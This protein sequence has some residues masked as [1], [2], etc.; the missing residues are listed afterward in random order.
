MSILAPGTI[1]LLAPA[2]DAATGMAAIRCGADAVYLGAPRFSAR[3]TAGNSISD[4]A[5]LCDLAHHYWARV[6]VALN[7]ILR[8]DELPHAVQ[9]A[10]AVAAAGA[11]GLIIQDVGLLASALPA[12]PLIASTQMHNDTPAKI[13]FLHEH[14]FARVILARELSLDELGRMRAAAPAIELECFVHG[15]VCVCYSGQCALSYALG[16]RSGNR[17]ACAQPCRRAY[18]LVDASGRVRGPRKYWLSLKDMCRVDDLGALLDAGLTSF[19]IE[20]RMK[21]SAYVMNTVAYY[22]DALDAQLAARGLRRSSSGITTRDFTPDPTKT[23]NRGFSSYFLHGT[24]E[25]VTA[26]DTP[27]SRG[28]RLGTVARVTARGF[29][30]DTATPVTPGDGICFVAAHGEL[31]GTTINAVIGAEIVPQNLHEIAVGMVIYRNF[32]QAFDKQLRATRT[33]REMGVRMRVG[34]TAAGIA[35]QVTDEDGVCADA[36]ITCEKSTARNADA[37]RAT[38]QRQLAKCGDTGFRCDEVVCA[39]AAV[40][41]V[42]VAQI[43]ELRRAALAALAAARAQQ[44]PRPQRMW[45]PPPRGDAAPQ[46]VLDFHGNVLNATAA[47]FYRAQGVAQIEPAAESG[48]DLHE[49]VLMTCKYCVRGAAG[50]CLR[51]DDVTALREPLYLVDEDGLRLRIVADCEKCQMAL[52]LAA[53][54]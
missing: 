45:Q 35:V 9:L 21:D 50:V 6:Y 20:G 1:E 22:R 13:A 52:V 18:T 48:L 19:K 46:T 40:W 41:F 2:R 53:A 15:A 33:R 3:E 17:G 24:N 49:R 44:R 38:L 42:P 39:T 43:N 12:I 14:G 27:K 25:D 54:R 32:D 4:I 51:R 36:A 28:A 23:F 37:M 10:H 31:T 16:G 29:V 26:L 7:T 30:L 47:A 34:A 8:D 11:D 5:A